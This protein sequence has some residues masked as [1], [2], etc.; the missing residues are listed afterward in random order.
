MDARTHHRVVVAGGG[1][2]GVEAILALRALAGSRVSI[3]LITPGDDLL[4]RPLAV[5]APFGTEEVRRFPLAEIC[6]D[7]RVTLRRDAV[8]YVD[9][10]GRAVETAAGARV[11]FDSLVVAVG[12]RRR[13]ALEGSLVFDDAAGIGAFRDLLGD[14][15][16]GS[17]RSVAFAVPG[18]T[19]WVLPLYE[20]A[21]QTAVATAGGAALTLVTPEEDPLTLFGRP[22]RRRV[23]ALLAEHGIAMHTSTTPLRVLGGML[24]T[25]G[26]T[27]AADR[28]VTL[29]ELTGPRVAGLPTD[30]RGFLPIDEHAAV[31]G[32]PGV[33]AAGDGTDA[34]VK[35]GGLAAQQADAAAAAIAAAAGAPVDPA[36]FRP[37]L[38]A[39]LLT[40]SL[41]WWFRGAAGER[42]PMAA[43]SPLWWPP[44]KVAAKHLAP[45]LAERAHLHVGAAA[46]LSDREPAPF[47]DEEERRA[48]L[49]LAL[50]LA[51]DEAAGGEPE[52]A[53]RWL[54]AAEGIAGTL[55]A[56]YLVKRRRWSGEEIDPT[57]RVRSIP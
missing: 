38:R 55:P 9:A 28:V 51:D 18:A 42:A 17:V 43:R 8:D 14:L 4:L 10:T 53:L 12:A 11:P 24:L 31:V 39:Q 34:V 27:V 52:L 25:S 7:Q 48:T 45:Y 44:G 32:A 36:P 21:L 20:L 49:D 46:S 16:D 13:P 35:Q 3:E 29:P 33:F 6:R 41:P 40:G 23:R 47:P 15:R 26:G 37:S 1:I 50:L 54:D 57:T 5:A 2:A 30:A 22:A 56:D 19:A